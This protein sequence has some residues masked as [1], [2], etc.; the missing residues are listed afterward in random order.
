MSKE[1]AYYQLSV[2]ALIVNN[3]K[4][5]TLFTPDGY[6]DFPGGRVDIDEQ[7]DNLENILNREIDEE[8][9]KSCKIKLN[10]VAFVTNRH[11]T[12]ASNIQYVITVFYNSKFENSN[13]QLS[14]EHSSYKWLTYID[15]LAYK[16]KFISK[17]EY[18]QFE[19]YCLK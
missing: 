9:G 1:F 10:N 13:I 8:L 19:K 4:I 15:M 11:Y 14:S 17:D 5:F 6:I 7:G 16:D 18:I 3:G 12:I 2:K